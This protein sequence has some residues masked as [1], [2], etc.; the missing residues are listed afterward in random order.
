[1]STPIAPTGSA[2]PIT[3]VSEPTLDCTKPTSSMTT[4]THPWVP[5]ASTPSV[6]MPVKGAVRIRELR[7]SD[8]CSGSSNVEWRNSY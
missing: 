1:M 3:S 4:P 5:A 8:N 7:S 6:R 2:H